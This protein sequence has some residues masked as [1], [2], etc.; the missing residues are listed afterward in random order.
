MKSRELQTTMD[1]LESLSPE[2]LRLVR[3]TAEVLK[4][5]DDRSGKS[6]V[7]KPVTKVYMNQKELCELF[8]YGRT[9]VANR[10]NEIREFGKD[11]YKYPFDGRGIHV[12]VFLDWCSNR[13]MLMDKNCRTYVEPF[14]VYEALEYAGV[15]AERDDH[16]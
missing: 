14:N 8:G 4:T 1:S 11:R 5:L 13:Q 9:V 15:M 3:G 16:R 2:M 7:V 6:V 10:V 12:G